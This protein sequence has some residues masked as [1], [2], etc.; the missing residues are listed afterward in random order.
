[1][2]TAALPTE[3]QDPVFHPHPSLSDQINRDI[4]QSEIEGGVSLDRLPIGAVLEVQTRNRI[5]TVEN[6]GD[7]DV[8][9]SGHPDYCPE[10]TPVRFQGSTW[11]RS[12]V[13]FHFLGRGMHLE[14]RHPALGV[15][16]TSRVEEIRER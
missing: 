12:L 10:P 13:K 6:L 15:I 14:F 1:M 4:C 7:G 9:L 8:L 11:G 2:P 3:V 16:R 5:Y